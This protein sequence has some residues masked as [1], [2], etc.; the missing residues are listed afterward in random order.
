MAKNV[1]KRIPLLMQWHVK[2]RG[3]GSRKT[4]YNVTY[5]API[6]L[7]RLQSLALYA[8]SHHP[9]LALLACLDLAKPVE[10]AAKIII[11]EK[12]TGLNTLILELYIEII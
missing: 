6:L 11:M 3:K 1:W 10:E 8:R 9:S 4:H 5:T 2:P 12:G 7:P